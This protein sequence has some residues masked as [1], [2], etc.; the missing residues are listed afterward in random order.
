MNKRNIV[1]AGALLG[2]VVLTGCSTVSNPPDQVALHVEDGPASSKK[3]KD[4]VPAGK[5]AW[6]GPGDKYYQYPTGQRT[7]DFTGDPK[8]EAGPITVTAKGNEGKG[9]A[10]VVV[11]G[12]A[13]FELNTDEQTL[14]LFHNRIG[15]KYKAYWGGSDFEDKDENSNETPDG[16]ESMLRMYMGNALKNV[17]QNLGSQ[18]TYTE[19]RGDAS[20][21]VEYQAAVTKALPAELK[22]L[23]GSD[24][25][26]YF[27]NITV[28]FNQPVLADKNLDST[29]AKQQADIA[30]SQAKEAKASADKLA[31]EAE[32]AVRKAEADGK[33]QEIKPFGSAEEYNKFKAI[34]KGL[35]PYQPQGTIVT[36]TEEGK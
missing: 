33:A 4:L 9:Q 22:R 1:L 24:D 7:Y 36:K 14:V 30:A 25:G 17:T 6:N 10:A 11:P 5:R 2:T 18:Y 31:A 19:L 29:I 21:R 8:S 35:N 13:T 26:D 28:T 23:L 34:E 27:Q 16:W 15:L 3:Y 20:K 32:I 12:V